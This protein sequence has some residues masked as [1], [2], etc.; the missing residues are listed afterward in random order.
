MPVYEYKCKVHGRYET[1]MQMS[2]CNDGVCPKCRRV[3]ER[4]FSDC[5]VYVDFTPGFDDSLNTW[6]DTKRQRDR[7][8]G[9]KGLKRYVD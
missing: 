8:C 2:E 6:V 1:V 5:H 4:L 7:I 9:E 3:G